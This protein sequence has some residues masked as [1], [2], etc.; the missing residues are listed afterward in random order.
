MDVRSVSELSLNEERS[1][2]HPT[3][4]AH[5]PVSLRNVL[6]VYAARLSEALKVAPELSD[7]MYDNWVQ[8]CKKET[9]SQDWK[10]SNSKSLYKGL[11]VCVRFD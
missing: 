10:W 1:D 11:T 9:V 5:G 7:S 2:V 4:L 8:G 3:I 6:F